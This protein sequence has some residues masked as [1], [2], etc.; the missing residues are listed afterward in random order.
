MYTR[1]RRGVYRSTEGFDTVA[2][3]ESLDNN[4]VKK[5]LHPFCLY[6]APA[7][8][9]ARGEKDESQYPPA[10]HL[11]H[12]ESGETVLGQSVFQAAD[13]TGLRSAFFTHNYVLPA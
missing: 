13:F 5:I 8:L 7:E 10:L 1:E 4:F 9:A 2:K 3:S 6:D 11:F 12:L